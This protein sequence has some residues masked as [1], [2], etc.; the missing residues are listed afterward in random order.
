MRF[1]LAVNNR[2]ILWVL[3]C[4]LLGGCATNQKHGPADKDIFAAHATL[5][6]RIS[7][8][9]EDGL[10]PNGIWK[11]KGQHCTIYLGGTVHLITPKQVP[12]P[13]AFYAAYQDA[14]EV[15][16]EVADGGASTISGARF[17]FQAFKWMRKH[18]AELVYPRGRTLETEL[19]PET[20]TKL[21]QHYGK[22]YNQRR[23]MTPLFLLF[24]AEAEGFSGQFERYG[25][26]EDVFN[27]FAHRDRKP[28][29]SLDDSSVNQLV[30]SMLDEMLLEL[31]TELKQKGVDVT[32][33]ESILEPNELIE[34]TDWRSGDLK[35]IEEEIKEFTEASPG[36]YQRVGPERNQKWMKKLKVLLQGEKNIIV[37]VGCAH[38]GGPEGLLS[39]LRQAGYSPEQLYGVDPLLP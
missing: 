18:K 2:T 31:S 1:L 10:V 14:S 13:S 37:L 16:L 4:F 17:L 39:L 28:V 11:V 30:F 6:T 29:R 23:Q 26:V 27:A 22:Q 35:K 38:L 33:I 36:L 9:P 21:K 32:L 12:F 7:T 19:A 8:K 25:G 5:E 20:V 24:L 3:I 34:E 15:Y